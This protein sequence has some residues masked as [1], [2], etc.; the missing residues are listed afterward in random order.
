MDDTD[1][2]KLNSYNIS[3][4]GAIIKILEKLVELDKIKNYIESKHSPNDFSKYIKSYEFCI[5]FCLHQIMEVLGDNQEFLDF[6]EDPLFARALYSVLDRSKFPDNTKLCVFA[7]NIFGLIESIFKKEDYEE[8]REF[9]PKVVKYIL[10]P[11]KEIISKNFKLA[12]KYKDFSNDEIVSRLA[13]SYFHLEFH[14]GQKI[15]NGYELIVKK[16][17][18]IR[19]RWEKIESFLM[20][21]GEEDN[22]S[23]IEIDSTEDFFES[24]QD[25]NV[26]RIGDM[27]EILG[28]QLFFK[29][30]KLIIDYLWGKLFTNP[31]SN[32]EFLKNIVLSKDWAEFDYYFESIRDEIILPLEKRMK[33]IDIS[34]KPIFL[35][36]EEIQNKTLNLL[37]EKKQ[38]YGEK[39]ELT[40]IEKLDASFLWYPVKLIES[41]SS[42]SCAD[43][44]FLTLRGLMSL[45]IESI[46][47]IR[48]HHLN[49][50][51]YSYAILVE[52]PKY[53]PLLDYAS[54]YVFLDFAT[55]YYG[56][57]ATVKKHIDDYIHQFDSII[58]VSD[59]DINSEAL[60]EY[61]KNKEVK[62]LSKIIGGLGDY[63]SD[64][65][66][67]VLELFN[68]YIF[69][70]LGYQ[71]HWSLKGKYT[72]YTEI[73][74]IIFKKF[75]KMYM[76]LISA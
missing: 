60:K 8:L 32:Y 9:L 76:K 36:Q 53:N 37:K 19:K 56:T 57:S 40:E 4:I 30:Y 58:H 62:Y 3:R 24:F 43:Q 25:R 6:K 38:F 41:G 23:V 50:H 14:D 49:R 74:L 59:R 45:N 18:P 34:F 64:A 33:A 63:K 65:K 20:E 35:K 27:Q 69:S 15:R 61:L 51:T 22:S 10:N 17:K 26:D 47:I 66:G 5:C 46:Q 67:M 28:E 1:I 54:W 52:G 72:D 11:F 13:K 70:K 75:Q 68:A 7:N 55:A 29:G 12:E 44:F 48:F 71:V 73:D 2:I 31:F 42:V 21:Q 39:A 16:G